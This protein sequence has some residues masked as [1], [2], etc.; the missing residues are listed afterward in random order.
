MGGASKDLPPSTCLAPLQATPPQLLLPGPPEPG[1]DTDPHRGTQRQPL[2][3]FGQELVGDLD[4]QGLQEGKRGERRQGIDRS[5]VDLPPP[6]WPTQ[7]PRSLPSGTAHS[8]GAADPWQASSVPRSPPPGTSQDGPAPTLRPHRGFL[9]EE[10][11]DVLGQTPGVPGAQLQV[12]VGTQVQELQGGESREGARGVRTVAGPSL[13]RGRSSPLRGGS[14]LPARAPCL[15]PAGPEGGREGGGRPHTA[16]P[17]DWGLPGRGCS[18]GR[19]P[20]EPAVSSA[21]PGPGRGCR[22]G[23]ETHPSEGSGGAAA[24]PAPRKGQGAGGPTSLLQY[25][26]SQSSSGPMISSREVRSRSCGGGGDR[27]IGSRWKQALACSEAAG[28]GTRVGPEAPAGRALRGSGGGELGGA[29]GRPHL[30]SGGG[31]GRVR[32]QPWVLLACGPG[33][34]DGR[35]AGA[36]QGGVGQDRVPAQ[37]DLPGDSVRGGGRH[38][39]GPFPA[40]ASQ[41]TSPAPLTSPTDG[42]R[43]GPESRPLSPSWESK[44]RRPAEGG[45]GCESPAAEPG[46]GGGGSSRPAPPAPVAASQSLGKLA[47]DLPPQMLPLQAWKRPRLWGLEKDPHPTPPTSG[48]GPGRSFLR[49]RPVPTQQRKAD[50][51]PTTTTPGLCWT[52]CAPQP[53]THRQSPRG[54]QNRNRCTAGWNPAGGTTQKAQPRHGSRHRGGG[55]EARASTGTRTHQCPSSLLPDLALQ[56]A[57]PPAGPFNLLLD[58]G[59]GVPVVHLIAPLLREGEGQAQGRFSEADCDPGPS[60]GGLLHAS[61]TG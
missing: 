15:G 25:P 52:T 10:V 46:G 11:P 31:E 38:I 39:G 40:A 50:P 41:G 2:T 47:Q 19:R 44:D 60:P 14:P 9:Q 61:P 55:T 56:L 26:G 33:R 4:P 59:H 36:L 18:A 16:V 51:P 1:K 48:P 32:A 24:K 3:Y 49:P 22:T 5:G 27:G 58:G 35:G 57:D 29:C 21:C 54:W 17:E 28:G 20:G 13:G 7:S 45:R 37:G 8:M 34:G 42:K 6:P 53:H 43:S 23:G 30:L 12:D